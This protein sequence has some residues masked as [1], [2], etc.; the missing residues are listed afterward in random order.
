MRYNSNNIHHMALWHSAL[1]HKT[2]NL[3]TLLSSFFLSLPKDFSRPYKYVALFQVNFRYRINTM[4]SI[5]IHIVTYIVGS[6][7]IT[8]CQPFFTGTTNARI[9]PSFVY[10]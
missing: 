2:A 3:F 8:D 5:L 4:Q 6:C 7:K 9:T 1:R 10:T